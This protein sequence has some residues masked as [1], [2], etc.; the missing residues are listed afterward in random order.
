MDVGVEVL[1]DPLPP[2]DQAGGL[3][4]GLLVRGDDG[5]GHR[6]R[7]VQR[8]EMGESAIVGS[9]TGSGKVSGNNAALAGE[10]LYHCSDEP[11]AAAGKCEHGRAVHKVPDFGV[12]TPA[13][14]R[15]VI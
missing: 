5:V 10:R 4:Q 2:S 8:D 7:V 9:V 14:E 1:R 13:M 6:L 11:F 3:R 15:H 12:R